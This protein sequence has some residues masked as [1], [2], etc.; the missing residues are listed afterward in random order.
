MSGRNWFAG[1]PAG[2]LT[3]N[4]EFVR[5]ANSMIGC[6][7]FNEADQKAFG[8]PPRA[9]FAIRLQGNF[10][11]NRLPDGTRSYWRV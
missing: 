7:V 1:S 11:I 10:A 9:V 6:V 4:L 2:S 8:I 5:D 3:S